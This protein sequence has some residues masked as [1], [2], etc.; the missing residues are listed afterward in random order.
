M[1][2]EL[3]SIFSEAC[4]KLVQNNLIPDL[5]WSKWAFKKPM[6]SKFGDFVSADVI[7]RA[8][9]Y[10]KETGQ[11]VIKQSWAELI[12]QEVC[13]SSLPS[14]MRSISAK[15]GFI[16]IVLESESPEKVAE[17]PYRVTCIQFKPIGI[18]SSCFNEKFGTPRQ[19]E[20][21]L[22][23]YLPEA[24]GVF[25][26]SDEISTVKS[27]QD[28]LLG[29]SEFSHIWILFLFHANHHNKLKAKIKPPRLE[30][31][32]R[33]IFATRSPHRFNSIGMSCVALDRVEGNKLYVSGVDMI[34]GTPVIDIKPYHK[35]DSL[36]NIRI[37]GYLHTPLDLYTV[38]FHSS[39]D[40]KLQDILSSNSLKYYTISDDVYSIICK[41]L[42][43]D[44]STLQTKLNHSVIRYTVR[45]YLRFQ[46]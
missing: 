11:V 46:L 17:D 24:R 14:F 25:T 20:L 7:R 30:G 26:L 41:C 34:D 9:K 12:T 35:A 1:I 19:S 39:A 13:S 33:G 31:E 18:L 6:N 43:Q 3:N 28:T 40:L 32:K 27:N 44:P 15:N 36:S 23:L 16:N 42:S 29:I 22:G 21:Y 37:P 45:R 38:K 10:T 2:P 5:D 8:S 4:S